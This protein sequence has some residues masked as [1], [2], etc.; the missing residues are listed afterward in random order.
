MNMPYVQSN[1]EGGDDKLIDLL[2]NL[3]PSIEHAIEKIPIE[4]LAFSCSKCCE[5][6]GPGDFITGED[7]IEKFC[8][9]DGLSRPKVVEKRDSCIQTSPIFEIYG[10]IPHI[11]SDEED[12]RQDVEDSFLVKN[13]EKV[14][15]PV[16]TGMRFS[17]LLIN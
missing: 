6:F 3:L 7:S 10:S 15:G 4:N 12:S 2:Q 11:D 8:D 1:E 13:L 9:C 14:S 16:S 17:F 5:Y